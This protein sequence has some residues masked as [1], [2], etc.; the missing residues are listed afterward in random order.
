M[1]A[2]IPAANTAAAQAAAPGAAPILMTY[3]SAGKA[4]Q[5]S[6]ATVRRLIKGGKLRVIHLSARAVRIPAADVHAL[7]QQAA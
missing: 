1:H 7:V 6:R 3:K 5:C 4:L 2:S